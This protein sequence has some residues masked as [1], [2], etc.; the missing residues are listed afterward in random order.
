[1]I[2][3]EVEKARLQKEIERVSGTLENIRNK[4]NNRNFLA[5]APEDVVKKERDKL[6]SFGQTLE[7]LEKNY[8]TLN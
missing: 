8:E 6:Q 7:K 4:L 5:K 2:D 3:L 1:V